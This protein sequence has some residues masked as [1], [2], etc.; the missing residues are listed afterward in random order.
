MMGRNEN[1]MGPFKISLPRTYDAT[2]ERVF[3]AWTDAHSAK[4]WLASG[5]DASVNAMRWPSSPRKALRV[6]ASSA[7]ARLSA[8]SSARPAMGLST[9]NGEG[10][11]WAMP[12]L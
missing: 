10:G 7:S 5:G 3:A 12:A 9:A 2:P 1:A 8:V 11:N 4:S 6:S